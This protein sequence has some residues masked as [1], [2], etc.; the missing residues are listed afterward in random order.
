[1]LQA[2]LMLL[3]LCLLI[4]L[5]RFLNGIVKLVDFSAEA[6]LEHGLLADCV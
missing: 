3:Y 5:I 6:G 1:M 4:P 2:R